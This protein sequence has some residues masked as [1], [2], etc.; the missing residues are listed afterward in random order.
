MYKIMIIEDDE[1]IRE[2]LKYYLESS[3]YNVIDIS[4]GYS[5]LNR[6]D[7]IAEELLGSAHY[8]WVLSYFNNIEDGYTALE[9]QRLMYPTSITAL[10]NP[11]ELLA[12][13]NPISLNLGEE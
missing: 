11:G 9:G 2:G 12:S 8:S 7:L 4:N 6:L 1:V 3:N 10:F 5:S 13:V